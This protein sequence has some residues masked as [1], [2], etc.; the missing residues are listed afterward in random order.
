MKTATVVPAAAAKSEGTL[1]EQV[2]AMRAAKAFVSVEERLAD[3][4]I[5]TQI[6]TENYRNM[7][8]FYPKLTKC[9][10]T[11]FSEQPYA[12]T[13]GAHIVEIMHAFTCH[14]N[15]LP[16]A[17]AEEAGIKVPVIED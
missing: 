14:C 2:H 8:A 11:W 1:L 4:I 6:A 16:E 3:G 17:E 12:F 10:T 5:K 15:S 13:E 7:I 9:F